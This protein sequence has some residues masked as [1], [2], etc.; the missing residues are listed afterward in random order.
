M[1]RLLGIVLLLTSLAAFGI[2][3]SRT[4]ELNGG[5]WNTLF[6][7]MR[8]ALSVTHFGHIWLWRVPA[9]VALW[10]AW[11][12]SLRHPGHR[13]APWLMVPAAAT[14]ALTR[15]NTGHPADHGDLKLAVWI[16]WGH[17]LAAGVWIGSLFGMTLALFPALL[18]Q[19]RDSLAPT[20]VIFQRLSTLS[21]AAL[22]VLLACGIYSVTWQLGSVA[23]LWTT[24][25]GFALDVKF[26]LVLTLL[27]IGSHNRYV[28]LPRL[29]QAIG[30]P[31]RASLLG[32]LYRRVF[33]GRTLGADNIVRACARAVLLESLLGI[34]VIGATAV[35]I[36]AMPPADM[37]AAHSTMTAPAAVQ[38][39]QQM[40]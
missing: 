1:P 6:H 18:R 19:G 36:H 22:A 7:D 14:L 33:S 10:L 23:A 16:D 30:L 27:A 35:L 20:V 40:N 39:S 8:L 13:W 9:L 25:Y 24:R 11:L 29:R 2:L 37:A 12:W 38:S 5:V 3:L 31:P 4:L 28:K 21:G 15:S 26:A 17:I 32:P 34:V